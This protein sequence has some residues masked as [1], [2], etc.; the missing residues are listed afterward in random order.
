MASAAL[1]WIALAAIA[2]PARAQLQRPSPMRM[3]VQNLTAVRDSARRNKSAAL[4]G[5]T[6][7][8]Q[9][10]FANS[11][12]RALLRVV[13]NNPIPKGLTLIPGTV[14]LSVPGKVDYSIDGGVTYV[15]QPVVTVT[16]NGQRLQRPAPPELYTNIRWSVAGS[17]PPNGSATARYEVRVAAR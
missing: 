1:T 7:R 15:D 16:Q 12:P 11:Q 13:F 6:L 2:L 8:Y 17:V 5:D 10:T 4:P 9:I 14:S 3:S